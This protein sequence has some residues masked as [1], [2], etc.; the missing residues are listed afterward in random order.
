MRLFVTTI[1]LWLF[2]V[3]T[4]FA[5]DVM[6]QR[7]YGGDG[8]DVGV[9]V[10]QADDNGYY[11]AGSSGSFDPGFSNQILLIRINEFGNQLW[12]KT[13]GGELAEWAES[14]VESA[15]GNLL[16]S[17]YTETTDNSYQFYA[18]KLTME[19]DTIWTRQYGGPSWDLC[20]QS[21][22]LPDGGFA[23]F[24]QTY[25]YGKGE[26]DFY[27]VRIDSEGDT[28]W[29]RT[30]GG[31]LDEN[32][33]SISLS[34]EGGFFLVGH[35]ESFGSGKRDGYIIKTDASGDTVWTRTIGGQEDEHLYGSCV[36]SDGGIV[37]VGG[38]YSNTPGESDRAMYRFDAGSGIHE[39]S[40]IFADS[41]NSDCYWTD[42]A[43]GSNNLLMACGIF[44]D[45]DWGKI[46]FRV[47]LVYSNG[48]WFGGFAKTRGTT[49]N[50]KMFDVKPTSDGGYITVGT[51]DGFLFR[52][53]D[54]YLHKMDEDGNTEFLE[55]GVEEISIGEEI[56]KVGFAPNPVCEVTNLIINNYQ[57]VRK[58]YDEQ[59][60]LRIYDAV[61][62]L[63]M[64]QPVLSARELVQTSNLSAGF[65]AYQLSSGNQVLATGR[66]IK[67]GR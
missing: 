10:I 66:L 31:D 57:T 40:S 38:T 23:L 19:G 63:V 34:D 55:V 17:G 45:S 44:H 59:L 60:T 1:C 3:L 13:Y 65:H 26:G 8:Y 4:V 58:H 20:Y 32:G 27:L 29:T 56:Y 24:G 53:D 33:Q 50:D 30:Y 41:T 2:S 42:I 37:V 49:S 22:A 9:E 6:F 61:G 62:H 67:V 51:T 15:D 54:V 47:E 18:M 28:I 5:Q 12:K 39:A 21:V 48:L 52:F 25:S 11:V 64:E 35:T 14:M 43:E 7:V 16:I 36:T 46:D